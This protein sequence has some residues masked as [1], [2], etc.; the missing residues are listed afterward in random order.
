MTQC[1]SY[2]GLINKVD[3][4]CVSQYLTDISRRELHIVWSV[5]NV[6]DFSSGLRALRRWKHTNSFVICG[7]KIRKW[8]NILILKI[9]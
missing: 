8:L 2:V 5:A 1:H 3:C 6:A 7:F 9:R 4:V